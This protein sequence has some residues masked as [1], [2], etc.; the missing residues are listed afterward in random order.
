MFGMVKCHK[1]VVPE[2]AWLPNDALLQLGFFEHHLFGTSPQQ[3][4]LP[5]AVQ[6]HLLLASCSFEGL[7]QWEWQSGVAPEEQ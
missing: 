3:S 4:H 1:Q 7:A 5:R 2:P 6:Q